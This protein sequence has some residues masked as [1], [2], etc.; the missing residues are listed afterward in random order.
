MA[1]INI[2][3]DNTNYSVDES[4]LSTASAALKSHM[5][6]VMNGTGATINLDG[7]TYNIDSAKLSAA[8]N[9]FISHLGTIAGNGYKVVVNGVEYSVGSDKV[10]GAVSELHTVLGGMHTDDGENLTVLDEAIL[11]DTILD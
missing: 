9:A 2:P 6:T 4:A 10:A 8:T 7:T 5:S 3:F 1:K 11:E